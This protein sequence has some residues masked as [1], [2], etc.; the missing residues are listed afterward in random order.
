MKTKNAMIEP[1]AKAFLP[2][3]GP[4]GIHFLSHFLED[5]ALK[6]RQQSQFELNELSMPKPL[7]AVQLDIES[8]PDS[9]LN[10]NPQVR[11]DLALSSFLF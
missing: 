10:N 3:M 2:N 11:S 1:L 9:I 4:T 8:E 6:A 5:R 7:A